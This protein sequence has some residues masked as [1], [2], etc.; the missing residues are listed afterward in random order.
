VLYLVARKQLSRAS[1]QKAEKIKRLTRK[2]DG[3]SRPLELSGALIQLK[4][5]ELPD[6]G[7]AL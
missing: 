3:C 4:L 5:S 7:A 2:P 6:H 1:N